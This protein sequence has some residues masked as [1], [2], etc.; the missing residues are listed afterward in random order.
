[1][2]ILGDRRSQC[3]RGG[4][5]GGADALFTPSFQE[6]MVGEDSESGGAGCAGEGGE[7]INERRMGEI[8]ARFG[9]DG[10]GFVHSKYFR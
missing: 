8:N 1:M 2:R 4:G 3:G 7:G 9:F 10:L 6:D 5:E